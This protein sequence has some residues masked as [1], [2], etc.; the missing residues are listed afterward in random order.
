MLPPM[1]PASPWAG[2]QLAD[3][4]RDQLFGLP[5]GMPPVDRSMAMSLAVV[6]RCRHRLFST[7]SRLP[8]VAS[9]GTE[10][11]SDQPRVVRQPEPDRPRALTMGWLAD[12]LLF[13]GRAWMVGTRYAADSDGGRVLDLKFV[14]EW[15]ARLDSDGN[16][17]G[18][19]GVDGDVDPATVYR[20]DGPHE[21]LLAYA[22]PTLERAW[23]LE[24]AAGRASDNPIPSVELHQTGGTALSREEISEMIAAWNAARAKPGGAVAFTN[25][26]VETKIHGAPVEQLLIDGR[27]AA[28]LDLARACGAPA[29]LADVPVEGSN[30][31]YG[32][33]SARNRDVIDDFVGPYLDAIS[34]RISQD[35]I[36]PAGQWCRFDLTE[37][38][39]SDFA[40]RMAAYKTAAEAG[41]YTVEE[42]QAIE[43]GRSL[44]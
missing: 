7:V 5:D 17:V 11:M 33:V 14:P 32:N 18:I 9:R 26:S 40:E 34:G 25:A 20:F 43:R 41:V 36:L 19:E 30:I 6:A 31:T 38:L 15:A 27:K 42:L 2:G 35:D 16:L 22:R 12:M 21:G 4:L 3:L 13:H 8:L 28:A 24:R 29:W 10:V 37:F 23:R 39:R 44:E 1:P